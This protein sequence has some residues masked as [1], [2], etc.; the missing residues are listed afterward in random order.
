MACSCGQ[1]SVPPTGSKAA[2]EAA[3]RAQA[4]VAA[5]NAARAQNPSVNRI[6]PAQSTGQAQSFALTVGGVV[7]TY[8]SALERDAAAARQTRVN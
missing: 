1:K 4:R 3:D 5:V 7:Q 2:R 8:G 6:G